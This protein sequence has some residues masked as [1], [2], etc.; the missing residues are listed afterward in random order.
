MIG[1]EAFVA[2][3]AQISV[4]HP[5]NLV[6]AFPRPRLLDRYLMGTVAGSLA[7]AAALGASVPGKLR[8]IRDEEDASRARVAV[9][10]ARVA[11]LGRNRQVMSVL[12]SEVSEEPGFKQTGRH[13]SLVRLAAAVPDSVT[14]NSLAID[15][16]DGFQIEAMV[17][18]NEFDPEGFRQALEQRGFKAGG[19]DG[20]KFDSATGKVSVRGTCGNP[21]Q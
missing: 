8:Q 21:R 7:L 6:E 20:W 4:S 5:G 14:L 2:C 9:L 11:D 15:R 17:V 3:A 12:R 19:Q 16:D 13:D 10:R 1:I 18:G